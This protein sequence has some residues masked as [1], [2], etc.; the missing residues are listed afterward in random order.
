[1]SQQQTRE[2][3]WD[4]DTPEGPARWTISRA[5]NPSGVVLALGHGAGGQITAKDLVALS[6]RLPAHGVHIAR[7][8]QPWKVAGKKITAAAP[9][10]DR[11][12][13]PATEVLLETLGADHLVVGGRSN[14]ARVAC[15]TQAASG[16][17]GVVCLA[18]PLHP[19]G[20]PE[21]SRASELLASAAPTLVLQGSKDPYGS[22]DEVRALA[23]ERLAGGQTN[24]HVVEVTG[25]PHSLQSPA[26]VRPIAEQGPWLTDQVL[27]F[28]GSLPPVP[29][30]HTG[31]RA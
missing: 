20:K 25:A 30:S 12:W 31:D 27:T 16:A 13:V 5:E 3:V 28:I 4:L 19:P 23:A 17:I 6:E 7:F 1:M 29:R 26:S 15:R 14:G 21:Q 22:A 9:V 18:F 24:L 11:A 8:T 2:E 10:L